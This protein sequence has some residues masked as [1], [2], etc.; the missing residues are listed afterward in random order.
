MLVR[1]TLDRFQLYYNLI[2]DHQVGKILTKTKAIAIIHLQR[3]LS[4]NTKSVLL[5]SMCQT[6]FINLLEQTRTKVGMQIVGNLSNA[7]HQ[8]F[9]VCVFH[10]TQ[11]HH[12]TFLHFYTAIHYTAIFT[13]S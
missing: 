11:F 13:T 10:F 1:N 9:E 12:S 8:Y 4:L 5:K 6:V 2:L 3:F 7:G